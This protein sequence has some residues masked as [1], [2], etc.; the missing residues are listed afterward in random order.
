MLS[1]IEHF[2]VLM[3]ENRSF[4][5]LL[6]SLKAQNPAIVGARD[7]EFTNPTDPAAPASP[8]VSVGPVSSFAMPFDPGHEFIDVQIQLYGR[9]QTAAREPAPRVDPAPMSGFVYSAELAAQSPAR[10]ALVMQTFPP[11]KLSVITALATEF[12]VFNYWHSSL[13]G[14][15]WP[16]RFFAHAATSGGLSDSPKDA[17]ILA[18]YTFPAGTIYQRLAEAQKTWRIYHDGLPHTAG[19]DSLRS[20]FLNVFTKNFREMDRFESDL[21]SGDLPDFVFIE[22]RYDTGHEFVGGNSMHPKND[23]RK[24][25]ALIKSVYEAIRSS[26]FWGETMFIVA[27]DEHGGFFDH[28]SPPAAIPPGG[29]AR[30]ANPVDH[31]NFDRLGVRVPAIV[32]S[33]YTNKGTVIGDSPLDYYDHTS[34]LATVEKRFGLQ[35]MTNRDKAAWDRTLE[36]ALNLTSPRLSPDEAP[37]SLPAPLRDGLMTR[38]LGMFVGAATDPTAPLSQSQRVQ[39]TLAHACNLQ[40][41]DPPERAAAHQRYLGVRGQADAAD[42]I[43]SVE[44]RIRTRRQL[45]NAAR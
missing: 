38:F 15:T 31:F 22:P 1:K 29:D 27:F 20:E 23:A 25:E 34:I 5:H 16:N 35:P 14:P 21:R 19:I 33:A 43:K 40:V 30:Y 4:D 3:L 28:V 41:L 32:V 8:T 45:A 12:A 24:G 2:V 44:D 36:T 39:L 11:G 26:R 37:M 17:D 7:N 18:G 9:A 6:G 10:A 42:Y 13:P